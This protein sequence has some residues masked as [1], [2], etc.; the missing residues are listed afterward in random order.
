MVDVKGHAWFWPLNKFV[1]PHCPGIYTNQQVE[2]WKKAVD[3]VHSKGAIIFCQLWH[4]GQVFNQ[5]KWSPEHYRQATLNAI[6]AGFDGVEIHAADGY[7]IDQFMNI[8]LN[9]QPEKPNKSS[10]KGITKFLMQVIQA[11]VGTIGADKLGVRI[12]P[13]IDRFEATDFNSLDLGLAVIEGLN[14]LQ[15]DLGS[16]LAYLHTTRSRLALGV[17]EEKAEGD[18]RIS[19]KLRDAFE[20]TFMSSGGYTKDQGM[21]AVAQGEADLVAYGRSFLSNPDLVH[22]FKVNAPMNDYVRATF[23]SQDPILG[24]TDYPFMGK[25]AIKGY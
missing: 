17:A 15:F 6:R 3:S 18:A 13:S 10:L 5:G 23:Y 12:S 4:V 22:R 14:K 25:E 2:S 19:K 9:D 1:P 21:K 16:K 24:Y 20:G 8:A 11:V 7:L